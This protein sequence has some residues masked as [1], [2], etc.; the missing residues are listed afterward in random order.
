ML[1]DRQEG[2]LSR[3][4]LNRSRKPGHPLSRHWAVGRVRMPCLAT[5]S[6][7]RTTGMGAARHEHLT[8]AR[9][10]SRRPGRAN[11]RV[12][13]G[14]RWQRGEMAAST[15]WGA[16]GGDADLWITT[17][18]G[19]PDNRISDPI[20]RR[21]MTG[22]RRSGKSGDG[23]YMAWKTMRHG[24]L[25]SHPLE[26]TPMTWQIRRRRGSQIT[27]LVRQTRRHAGES[28]KCGTRPAPMER[29][30]A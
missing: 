24:G 11:S 2:R 5:C 29:P 19:A 16:V 1:S 22:S 13:T 12:P 18:V 27:S 10:I 14:R 15:S 28:E 3:S 17:A 25:A 7:L 6:R 23:R 8:T 9:S 30:S 4:T 20:T 21:V 26:G